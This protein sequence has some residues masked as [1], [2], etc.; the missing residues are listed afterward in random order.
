[1]PIS[2]YA[3]LWKK[4]VIL[5]KSFWNKIEIWFFNPLSVFSFHHF[6]SFFSSCRIYQIYDFF[7]HIYIYIYWLVG[8]LVGCSLLRINICRLFNGKSIFMKIVIFQTNQFRI[9]TQFKCKYCLIVKIFLFPAIQFNQAFLIQLIQFSISQD[10]SIIN[11]S[12]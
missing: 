4:I 9:S 1:M 8:W 2:S 12:V 7:I 11:K 10:S 5:M 6:S 3:E